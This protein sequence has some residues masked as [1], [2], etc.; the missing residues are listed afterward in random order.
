MN[1]R[2]EEIKRALQ[3]EKAVRNKKDY[4]KG[5]YKDE[6]CKFSR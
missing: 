2:R 1:E 3:E 4:Y 6:N 5:L